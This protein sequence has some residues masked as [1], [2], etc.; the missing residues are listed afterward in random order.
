MSK[1]RSY[2]ALLPI[3]SFAAC[4]GDSDPVGV[5]SGDA[6]TETEIQAVFFALSD[7]FASLNQGAAAS[8]PA[9]TTYPVN[10]TVTGNAVCPQGGGISATGSVR[11]SAT[12]EPF[13]LDIRYQVRLSPRGCVVTTE[14]GTVTLDAKPHLE[15]A[16][17]LFLT[18]S[19]IEA[20]GSYGGGIAFTSTD[21]R[22]GSCAFDVSF[23]VSADLVDQSGSSVVSGTVCNVSVS[24]LQAFSVD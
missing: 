2:L 22:T 11:G 21:G 18:E 9:M 12:D 23:D 15:L 13:E 14:G 19:V 1:L 7:A 10:E 16:A 17:N 3:A 24:G 8:G 20:R 4:G 6:L 5:N